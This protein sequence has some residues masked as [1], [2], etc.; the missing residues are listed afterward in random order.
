METKK[1]SSCKLPKDLNDFNKSSRRSDGRQ[2]KCRECSSRYNTKRYATTGKARTTSPTQINKANIPALAELITEIEPHLRAKAA[3][4]ADDPMEA[5]DVYGAMVEAILTKSDPTDSLA[6]MLQRA[7]WA[8]SEFMNKKRTYNYRVE[9]KEDD[10]ADFMNNLSAEDEVVNHEISA[11]LK[12]VI[13]QL[14]PEYQ[15]VVT[16]LA[17]GYNQ[18]EIARKMAIS[19]QAVSAK[20]KRIGASMVNLGFMPA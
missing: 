12:A 20:V 11:E 14:A 16:L 13:A 1:C 15:Q 17:M 8:A 18:T 10:D 9:P 19:E 7:D 3:R 5:D 2:N 6:R 4:Y